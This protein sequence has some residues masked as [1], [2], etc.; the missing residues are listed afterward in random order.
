M[1]LLEPNSVR[2]SYSGFHVG[3]LESCHKSLCSISKVPKE[4]AGGEA[5]LSKSAD[6]SMNI[7]R[8]GVIITS[9]Q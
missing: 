3:Y 6:G 4:E 9:D 2:Y 5:V 7:I 1:A 8:N